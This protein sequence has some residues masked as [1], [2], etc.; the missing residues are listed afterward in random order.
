MGLQGRDEMKHIEI[1]KQVIEYCSKIG[2]DPLL[3][4][5]AGGNVS[6]K[7]SDT[8][9][10]KASGTRLALSKEEDIF[11][12]VSLSNILYEVDNGNFHVQP[13]PEAPGALRPSIETLLHAILPWQ[14]VAHLHA[15]N[16]LSVLVQSNAEEILIALL[17]DEF[18]YV[19]VDY[20]KPGPLLAK[21]IFDKISGAPEVN[22]VFMK[23]HGLVVAADSVDELDQLLNRLLKHFSFDSSCG[24]VA[25]VDKLK[26]K[27]G[28]YRQETTYDLDQLAI[29][30][31]YLDIVKNFWVMYPDHV[32]FLGSEPVIFSTTSEFENVISSGA[33]PDIVFV[34]GVGVW[35][36]EEMSS[37][38][39]E[40]L[41]CYYEVVIRLKEGS[42]LRGLTRSE[43]SELINWDAE[44]Y[45]IGL[46]K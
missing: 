16:V 43:I 37:S 39:T 23:N 28:G 18:N 26:P 46:N 31:R 33:S 17:G 12:P 15:V 5:G 27:V 45:R 34:E 35:V 25:K 4:Q 20:Y 8:L 6:W 1:R 41:R 11:T 40:Q 30:S 38:K 9:W 19:V 2:L 13:M 24:H 22:V 21:A 10:I 32:V 3:V 44:I 36:G 7:D 14:V 42:I 29:N